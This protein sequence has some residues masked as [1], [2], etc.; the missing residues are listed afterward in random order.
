VKSSHWSLVVQPSRSWGS[1][2][3]WWARAFGG[4]AQRRHIRGPHVYDQRH[5]RG[6]GK[7]S[8]TGFQHCAIQRGGGG[9]KEPLERKSTQM[10]WFRDIH[11]Y[12]T[13]SALYYIESS[14][15]EATCD[16]HAVESA[17]VTALF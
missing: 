9:I 11:G 5:F 6:R 17:I 16:P 2:L 1:S 13:D 14:A 15:R 10:P 3:A 7:I 8:G 12:W 4:H